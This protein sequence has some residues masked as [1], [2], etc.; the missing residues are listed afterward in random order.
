[1]Q[2][3]DIIL[4]IY[5]FLLPSSSSSLLFCL[6]FFFMFELTFSVYSKYLVKVHL[7]EMERGEQREGFQLLVH[8]PSGRS[9][10]AELGR[11]ERRA[12][13]F[14]QGSGARHSSCLIFD[15]FPWCIS[16]S[17]QSLTMDTFCLLLFPRLK[18]INWG[19]DTL[20]QGVMLPHKA[21]GVTYG[22]ICC[23]S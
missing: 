9:V 16:A 18:N 11:L 3:I 7:F 15:W 8:N 4:R 19:D 13:S 22:N 20:A 6:P 21:T 2:F 14:L 23:S 17:T 12:G 5:T 1:M 10:Q